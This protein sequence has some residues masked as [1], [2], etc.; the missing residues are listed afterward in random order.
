MPH[1]GW[2]CPGGDL[3]G[4]LALRHLAVRRFRAGIEVRS[5]RKEPAAVE[6]IGTAALQYLASLEY[7][8][9]AKAILGMI[10]LTG[11]Y[12][13]DEIPDHSQLVR[14]PRMSSPKSIVCF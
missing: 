7:R 14:F 1:P 8:P 2:V 12:W 11:I 4:S 13:V 3:F 5:L 9:D 10:P 6:E